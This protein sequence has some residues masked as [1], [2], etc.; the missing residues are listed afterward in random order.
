MSLSS[1]IVQRGIASIREIEEALARQVLYGGDFV[2]NLFEVSH[3][4]EAALMPVVAGSYGLPAADPGELPRAPGE[5]LRLVAAEVVRERAFAPLEVGGSLVV[6]VA[7]PLSRDAEQELTFA[8]ALPIE[9]RVA[10]L[11]RIRQALA[12]DYGIPPDK[13]IARL[14]TKVMNKGPRIASTFPPPL[15][16]SPNHRAPPRPPSVAPPP[17]APLRNG[18]QRTAATGQGTLVRGT[19]APALRPV[20]RRRG[21]LTMDVARTELE[22][23]A[24]RDVI[25]DIL[26]EFTRQFFDYT[27]LFIAHGDIAEGRDAFGD[28]ASRDK[29]ARVGVPLDL[30]SLLARAREAKRVVRAKPSSEGIDPVLMA[31]LGRDG[32]TEC[33]VVPIIV[34][35]RVVGLLLGDGGASGIDDVGVGHVEELVASA[36]GAFERV[37]MRRKLKGE[38]VAEG[39][40][41][42]A[43]KKAADTVPPPATQVSALPPSLAASPPPV[44]ELALPIRELM[45]D[46]ASGAA[47]TTREP[48]ATAQAFLGT[49]PSMVRSDRPPPANLLAVRRPSGRPIPREEPDP[50]GDSPGRSMSTASAS[51]TATLASS[52]WPSGTVPPAR[53]PSAR[54]TTKSQHLRRAEAPRL[55]FGTPSMPSVIA[56]GASWG[57]TPPAP[58]DI[59]ERQLIAQIHGSGH[60]MDGSPM[61]ARQPDGVARWGGDRDLLGPPEVRPRGRDPSSPGMPAPKPASESLSE[62]HYSPRAESP[63][64]VRVSSITDMSPQPIGPIVPIDAAGPGYRSATD[65]SAAP[66]EL[67]PPASV[68]VHSPLF[69]NQVTVA[70]SERP[71]SSSPNA[72]PTTLVAGSPLLPMLEPRIDENPRPITPLVVVTPDREM[73]PVSLDSVVD[74]DATPIAPPVF[75]PDLQ[76]TPLAGPVEESKRPSIDPVLS[77]SQRKG[78]PPVLPFIP[79][80]KPMPMSEQQISVAAHR[81][82]SSRSDH[83][84]ILPSVIVDVSSEYVTLVERVLTEPD[85]EAETTLLRAGAYAMPAIMAKFPGPIAIELERLVSGRLP[86]VADCGPVIRLV[87]SQRRTALPFVLALVESPD[88]EARF[89][90]TYLLTELVYP[91]AIDAAIA[92]NF[93][94]DARVR[95]AAR[96]ACRALA[97]VHPQPVIERLGE[98]ANTQSMVRRVQAIEAL[99][100]TRE[101][102]AVPV[103]LPLLDDGSEQVVKAVRGAL[104]TITQQDFARDSHRWHD[105][106]R[107]NRSRHRLEW[108][109]DSLMHDSRALR[110]SA[111]EELRTITKEF[112]AYYD[113]LP[114]RERERAQARYR[115]WWENIGRVRFSRASS[116]GA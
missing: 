67:S 33:V 40:A 15:E 48:T 50:G 49:D 100:E 83:S 27:A 64:P 93:D 42:G 74:P 116:R 96:A 89:W 29:V 2:T 52:S 68:A 39:G 70:E 43:K 61:T 80:P 51:L 114:K 86:R 92:R 62:I 109:I 87:A 108:L 18:A 111:S 45:V 32:T 63:P 14:I 30:A 97:E 59:V 5:A 53:T 71:P 72:A 98:I 24:E 112:F 8:L 91:D 90:A 65:M 103:L 115:E 113:D 25:F 10:P 73:R 47:T 21:P 34:R 46:P 12:R 11:F 6:A 55:E 110:G 58:D 4:E 99:G 56:E 7:E 76:P 20:R 23:S 54:P 26:F 31:D 60:G 75:D 9:Q 36:S 81:P 88:A 13:R 84:R 22:A 106:W 19:E 38:G 104:V 82:P 41:A 57:V 3:V 85:D 28:G 94:E 77:L 37:I 17:P 35:T 44:E 102:L 107:E 69:T 66:L 16:S 105:W 79:E 1:L 95:R 101:P 78:A